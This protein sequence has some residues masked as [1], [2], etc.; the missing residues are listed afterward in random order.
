MAELNRIPGAKRLID[1][2][3]ARLRR[4][5]FWAAWWPFL[6]LVTVYFGAVFLGVFERGSVQIATFATL[7]AIVGGLIA[8]WRGVRRYH[9][10]VRGDAISALDQQSDL[11]PL[12]SLADRPAR[13]EL[14]ATVLWQAH[15]TRLT[16]AVRRLSVPAFSETWKR[17]DPLYLR[18]VLPALFAAV[19]ALNWGQASSRLSAAMNPDLGSLF[20]AESVRIEAWITPPEHTGRAPIFLSDEQTEARVPAGSIMTLRVQAPSRPTLRIISQSDR[21]RTRF[22]P[23]PDGAFETTVQ[24]QDNSTVSV[25]WWGERRSWTISASPDAAPEV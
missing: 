11:R 8:I 13:P 6:A 4:L 22:E 19:L 20:G 15:E 9:T 12:A 23:T 25:H 7:V 16:D 21:I 1:R 18:F 3:I 24:I 5:A 17:T 2:T 14:T 10:P